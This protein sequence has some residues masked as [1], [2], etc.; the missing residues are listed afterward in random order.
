MVIKEWEYTNP[1]YEILLHLNLSWRLLDNMNIEASR[2]LH[3]QSDPY[4][5]ISFLTCMRI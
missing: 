2:L 3:T 1:I 5:I 4:V